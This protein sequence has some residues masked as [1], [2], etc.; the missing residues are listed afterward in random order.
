MVNLVECSKLFVKSE[1]I[2]KYFESITFNKFIL[3]L[4]KIISSQYESTRYNRVG[5]EALE[6]SPC[7]SYAKK[8]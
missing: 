3:L 7:K 2:E 8:I 5:K 4:S 1:V 6:L